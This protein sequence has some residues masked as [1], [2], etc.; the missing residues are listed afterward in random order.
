MYNS[1]VSLPFETYADAVHTTPSFVNITSRILSLLNR[2]KILDQP[3]LI[4]SNFL[5]NLTPTA[6]SE[7]T[8]TPRMFKSQLFSKLF[9]KEV[10]FYRNIQSTLLYE[11]SFKKTVLNLLNIEQLRNFENKPHHWH[12]SDIFSS[13]IPNINFSKSNF[14]FHLLL[15]LLS[16]RILSLTNLLFLLKIF[17]HSLFFRFLSI[18]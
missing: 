12:Y 14:I 9:Q 4:L 1:T 6:P 7:K 13:I 2:H 8:F 18:D 17:N 10:T 16:S 15:L 5:P 11:R 3:N